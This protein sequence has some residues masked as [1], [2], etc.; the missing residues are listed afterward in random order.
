MAT[1]FTVQE[2]SPQVRPALLLVVLG[3]VEYDPLG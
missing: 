1:G 3:D 2:I